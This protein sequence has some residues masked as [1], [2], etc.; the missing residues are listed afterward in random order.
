[1]YVYESW[2]IKKAE[3]RRLDAFELWCWRR[4]LRVPWTARRS[5]QSI[6]KDIRPGCS[7]EEMILKLKLQLWPH[8]AKSWLIGKDYDAGKDWGQDE[9]GMA[10]RE[11]WLA[12][13]HGVRKIQTWLGD[14]TESENKNSHGRTLWELSFIIS[15]QTKVCMTRVSHSRN[16]WCRTQM[17]SFS[18]LNTILLAT[19]NRYLLIMSQIFKCYSWLEYVTCKRYIS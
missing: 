10:D 17:S 2:T 7:L 14:W 15:Y 8:N 9:K 3:S 5:N 4:L 13:V 6:L 19:I 1:M 12:V 11:A 16:C 18:P